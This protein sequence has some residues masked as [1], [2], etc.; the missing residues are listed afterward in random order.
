MVDIARAVFSV[1]A[2]DRPAIV[3]LE[4]IPR[5]ESLGVFGGNLPADVSDD[6]LSLLDRDAREQAESGLGS[7]DPEM[8]RW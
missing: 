3:D 7:A 2:I 8:T 5:I 1:R 4:Q 6:E